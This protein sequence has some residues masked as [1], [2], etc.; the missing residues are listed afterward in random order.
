MNQKKLNQIQ[1][2]HNNLEVQ[3]LIQMNKVHNLHQI[4]HKVQIIKHKNHHLFHHQKMN[5][6]LL[7]I[8]I[9]QDYHHLIWIQLKHIQVQKFHL[10]QIMLLQIQAIILAQIQM[11]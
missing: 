4:L 11:I 7:H 2:Q 6:N 9:L 5:L 8:N 3:C 10:I 1:E